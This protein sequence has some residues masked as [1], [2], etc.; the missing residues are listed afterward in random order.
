MWRRS[1]PVLAGI[2]GE[3]DRVWVH[4]HASSLSALATFIVGRRGAEPV[5]TTTQQ[6]HSTLR[7]KRARD[8]AM[9]RFKLHPP[10]NRIIPQIDGRLHPLA[11][12]RYGFWSSSSSVA[13]SEN[14]S[15]PTIVMKTLTRAIDRLP[16]GVG[17]PTG[18]LPSSPNIHQAA[19]TTGH[20]KRVRR[21]VPIMIVSVE[22]T[23]CIGSF[24]LFRLCCASVGAISPRPLATRG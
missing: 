21:R 8:G 20:L 18:R 12:A 5:T 6:S 19:Y 9:I 15:P 23:S 3:G 11:R 10:Y 4:W 14:G 22:M 1:S 13:V 7:A 16:E 2:D 24:S 17:G